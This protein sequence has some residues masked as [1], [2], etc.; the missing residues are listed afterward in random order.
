MSFPQILKKHVSME[1]TLAHYGEHSENSHLYTRA[2]SDKLHL[3][4]KIVD[5]KVLQDNFSI[6]NV[7]LVIYKL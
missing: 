4:T 2:G 5:R 6:Y 7:K 3:K 1:N